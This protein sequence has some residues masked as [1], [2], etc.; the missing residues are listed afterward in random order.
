[1]VYTIAFPNM[2]EFGSDIGA[3]FSLKWS[4]IDSESVI[5]YLERTQVL[6]QRR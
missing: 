6:V 5:E 3:A 4:D 2:K 1:M